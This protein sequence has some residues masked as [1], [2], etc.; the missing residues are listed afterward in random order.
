[1]KRLTTNQERSVATRWGA[2]QAAGHNPRS[3]WLAHHASPKDVAN[4]GDCLGTRASGHTAICSLENRPRGR[5]ATPSR[6][7]AHS[8]PTAGATTPVFNPP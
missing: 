5:D 6:P 3:P 1:M 7:R 4:F 8:V 2:S